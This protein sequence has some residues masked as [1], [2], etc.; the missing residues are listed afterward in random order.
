MKGVGRL[1]V[2]AHVWYG[3]DREVPGPSPS[4]G[5]VPGPCSN[6]MLNC[7]GPAA[8]QG[9]GAPQHGK[10]RSPQPDQDPISMSGDR[11]SNSA[12]HRLNSWGLGQPLR[13]GP[14]VNPV[15]IWLDAAAA[16]EDGV[17]RC[18]TW[19]SRRGGATTTR[20]F[21]AQ[22]LVTVKLCSVSRG[23]STKAL[24]EADHRWPA[25]WPVRSP[26]S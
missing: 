16:Y 14:V 21:A 1:S 5:P 18:A 20:T 15:V 24:G 6:A 2:R 4:R 11:I 3:G 23:K 8:N 10:R 22:R 17:P 25:Q 12:L 26:E 13:W 7:P 9:P 19:A